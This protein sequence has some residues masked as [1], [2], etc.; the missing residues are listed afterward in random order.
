MTT[1]HHPLDD[2]PGNDWTVF[3]RAVD[4]A[5]RLYRQDGSVLIHCTAG[6]SRSST[7]IAT[8]LAAEES[9]SLRESLSAVLQTRPTTTPHPALHELAVVYVAART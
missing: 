6:I 8:V 7:V 1:H 5:H 3:A 9:R 4:T 2:G